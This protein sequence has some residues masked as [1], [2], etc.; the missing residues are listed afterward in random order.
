MRECKKC[1]HRNTYC[2]RDPEFPCYG[3]CD[4]CGAKDRY[5]CKPGCANTDPPTPKLESELDRLRRENADLRATVDLYKNVATKIARTLAD[6]SCLY[7]GYTLNYRSVSQALA[8]ILKLTRPDIYADFHADWD[9]GRIRRKW[10]V[11]EDET[12]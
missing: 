5:P 7:S 6:T 8:D 9:W 2:M 3:G 11:P 4:L 12:P 10:F 1:N